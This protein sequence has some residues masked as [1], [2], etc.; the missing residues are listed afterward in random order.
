M[1]SLIC[2]LEI[3]NVVVPDPNIFLWIAASVADDAA[4]NPNVIKTVLANDLNTFLV[5]GNLVFSNGTKSLPRNH[6]DCPILCNW[7]FDNFILADEPFA[8]TLQSFQRFVLVNS[9]LWG[10]LFSSSESPII[11]D[12]ILKVI[13]V[14]FFI[15]DFNLLSR[16]SILHLKFYIDLFYIKA[17]IKLEYFYSSLWKM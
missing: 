2:L 16:E 12:E 11:I 9:N 3:I 10:K 6:P 4:V 17:K 13:S 5:K 7:V 15:Y 1:I 14:P 8:K